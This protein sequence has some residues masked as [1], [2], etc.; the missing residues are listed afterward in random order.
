MP[1]DTTDSNMLSTVNSNISK[2]WDVNIVPQDIFSTTEDANQNDDDEIGG[3]VEKGDEENEENNEEGIENGV[4]NEENGDE[5]ENEM[6]IDEG[7]F[8][9]NTSNKLFNRLH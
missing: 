3:D 6:E 9:S 5:D 8:F 4:E 2:K 1:V 7:N